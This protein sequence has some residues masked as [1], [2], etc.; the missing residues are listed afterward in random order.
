LAALGKLLAHP[1]QKIPLTVLVGTRVQI[2]TNHWCGSIFEIQESLHE[3]FR[4]IECLP[5]GAIQNCF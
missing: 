3:R 2:Q 5:F 4:L 1:R